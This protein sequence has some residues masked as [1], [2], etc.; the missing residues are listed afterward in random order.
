MPDK[1]DASNRLPIK[2]FMTEELEEICNA[3]NL[4][5]SFY[6]TREGTDWKESVQRYEINLLQNV[7]R[8]QKDIRAEQYKMKPAVEFQLHERGHK[9]NI[10]S[11]HISDRVVLH[12]CCNNVLVPRVRPKLIYDNG[13]SLEGKGISFSRRRFCIHLNKF[14]KEH[15]NNGYIRLFDFKKFFDNIPHEKALEQYKP[16]LNGK[17]FE[18][19][20]AIFKTFEVDVSYMTDEQYANCMQDVF[21][22]LEYVKQNYP[23]TRRKMMPKS[24]GIGNQI[25]QIT[26]VFFPHRLDNFM[27]I[28]CGVKYYGRYMDDFYILAETKEE[29]NALTILIAAECAKQGLF[30]N[31]KKIRTS[32]L[33]KEFVFLKTI[34]KMRSNGRIIKRITKDNIS[35][36]RRKI[37][38]LRTL[39]DNGRLSVEHATNCYKSWRG[40]YKNYDSHYEILKMDNLFLSV[41]PEVNKQCLKEK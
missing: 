8:S 37:R 40:S 7:R 6:K 14:Y 28:V 35:R 10:K 18:F 17:E 15:G 30:L 1:S 4:I 19:V 32:P 38:K 39:V 24:V 13:A 9:R 2:I 36:E 25:S 23:Q 22:S 33:D 27:K 3:N 41:F 26:G 16:L 21:N 11:L 5:S 31:Y 12:S 34:Y 29:L 20:Q